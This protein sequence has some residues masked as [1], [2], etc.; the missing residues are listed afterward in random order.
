[1]FRFPRLYDVIDLFSA[2]IIE[3]LRSRS[4]KESAKVSR[5]FRRFH[6]LIAKI[7]RTRRWRVTHVL[8]Q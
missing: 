4:Q 8:G 1:M 7:P 6:A 5:T 2:N 3:A